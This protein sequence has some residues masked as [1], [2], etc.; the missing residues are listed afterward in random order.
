MTANTDNVANGISNSSEPISSKL[1]LSDEDTVKHDV[2]GSVMDGLIMEVKD[3]YT[4]FRTRWVMLALFVLY[5]ASNSLQW[6]QFT[7]ISDIIVRYYGVTSNVVS[8]TSMVY[9]ITYV[10]L[11]FPAS[12]LLDKTVS[13][14]LYFIFIHLEM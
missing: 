5:S 10:P 11:I 12:W 3:S 8:W 2:S 7:I 1:F 6:T 4:V 14:F 9:M 13:E